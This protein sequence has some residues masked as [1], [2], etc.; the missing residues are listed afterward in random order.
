MKDNPQAPGMDRNWEDTA[1]Q[2]HRF[3]ARQVDSTNTGGV[4]AGISGGLDSA[5]LAF[6]AAKALASEAGTRY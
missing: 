5:V 2:I 4:V 6:L 1:R 3:I